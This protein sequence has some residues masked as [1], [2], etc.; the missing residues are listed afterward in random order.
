[1]IEIAILF[2]RCLAR[3]FKT[4][5]HL[6]IEILALRHQLCVLQRGV[7]RPKIRPADRILWSLLSRFWS[8]WKEALIFV[9]PDTVI[10][11]Q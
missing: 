4:R 6:Q 8:D 2:F 7:K 9:K 11:W 5:I 1:M 3:P 10:R